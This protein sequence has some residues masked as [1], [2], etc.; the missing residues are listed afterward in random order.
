MLV[1]QLGGLI[2]VVQTVIVPV[3][4]PAVLNTAIILTG[5]FS[6]LAL[7]RRHVGRVC[8]TGLVVSI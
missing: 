4:L 8:C 3:T 1:A 7:R 5:K 2:A 6:R